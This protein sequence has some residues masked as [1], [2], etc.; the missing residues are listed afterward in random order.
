MIEL[1]DG[2]VHS[3]NNKKHL[4]ALCSI[5]SCIE[6]IVVAE[7]FKN[8]WQVILSS[9][10]GQ[11]RDKNLNELRGKF[12]L[13]RGGKNK[14]LEKIAKLNITFKRYRRNKNCCN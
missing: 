10:P 6:T 11:Y 4:T 2:Y 12:I 1:A 3:F 14:K 7:Q 9:K 8:K 5:R 13:G